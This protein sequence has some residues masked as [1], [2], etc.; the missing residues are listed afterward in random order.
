MLSLNSNFRRTGGTTSKHFNLKL[1]N[2]QENYLQQIY[3]QKDS[4]L[5]IPTILLFY[6]KKEKNASTW[7][8]AVFVQT[9]GLGHSMHSD[10]LYNKIV[11]F[12]LIDLSFSNT[13][14]LTYFQNVPISNGLSDFHLI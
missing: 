6:L 3:K 10:E 5:T 11:R 8:N 2:F 9:S 1:E 12:Y 13:V 7:K 4:L 14:L